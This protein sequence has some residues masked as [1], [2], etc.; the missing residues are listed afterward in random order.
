MPLT[1]LSLSVPVY[2]KLLNMNVLEMNF[3]DF[4]YTLKMMQ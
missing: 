2:I 1:V 4:V 3:H